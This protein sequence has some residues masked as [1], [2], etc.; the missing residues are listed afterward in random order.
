MQML[1]RMVFDKGAVWRQWN[2]GEK[3]NKGVHLDAAAPPHTVYLPPGSAACTVFCT[4]KGPLGARGGVGTLG[5]YIL[6]QGE[7]SLGA[8][9]KCKLI[10]FWFRGRE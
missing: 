5:D 1:E 4:M 3:G 2:S 10:I 7:D 8:Q 9:Q 6:P